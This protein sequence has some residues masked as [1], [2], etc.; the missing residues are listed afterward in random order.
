MPEVELAWAT[1]KEREKAQA[2]ASAKAAQ[3]SAPA[4]T[5]PSLTGAEKKE[6][7]SLERQIESL[8]AKKAGL[9]DQ[10]SHPEVW[11]GEGRRGRELTAKKEQL[12]AELAG[13]I[14]RWEQL[15]ERA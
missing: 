8:E 4:P 1:Y 11:E 15:A 9:E 14:A 13:F 7:A 2:K 10:L 5:K 6:L 12:E 3:K